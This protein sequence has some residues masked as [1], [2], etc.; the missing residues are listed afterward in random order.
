MATI[1]LKLEHVCAGGGHATI[2]VALN[3]T[4]KGEWELWADDVLADVTD[5]EIEALMKLLI[6]AHKVG[7]T[8][9]EVRTDLQAGLTITV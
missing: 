5:E 8:K 7:R 1:L 6:R 2:S 9:A 3:G 4:P